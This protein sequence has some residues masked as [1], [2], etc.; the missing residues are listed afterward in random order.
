MN[1]ASAE[2]RIR[3]ADMADEIARFTRAGILR[4]AGAGILA[5]DRD[6]AVSRLQGLLY[7]AS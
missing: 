6:R 3:D 7:D 2:S 5:S 4:Q 1:Q